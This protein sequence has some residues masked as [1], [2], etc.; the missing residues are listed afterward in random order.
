MASFFPFSGLSGKLRSPALTYS[1]ERKG[2]SIWYN[3]SMQIS[4]RECM[5]HVHQHSH[6]TPSCWLP[7]DHKAHQSTLIASHFD[8]YVR[9]IP[10]Y[11]LL[12]VMERLQ[13][14]TGLAQKAHQFTSIASHFDTYVRRMFIN[15]PL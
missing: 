7:L 10:V 3:E 6:L 9:R 15:I 4:S 8:T 1:G 14:R 11:I 2:C 5:A 13:V 12:I